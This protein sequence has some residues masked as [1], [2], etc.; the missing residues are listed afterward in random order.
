M[1][2]NPYRA[3]R[4]A[5]GMSLRELARRT[6]INP[7]RLSIV[8]RGVEPTA[9]ERDALNRELGEMLLGPRSSEPTS[10]S[11]VVT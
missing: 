5:T 2:E 4:E 6:G 1:S 11:E 9:G 10:E 8:E 3:M 7:G